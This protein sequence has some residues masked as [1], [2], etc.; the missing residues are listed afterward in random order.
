MSWRSVS[1]RGEEFHRHA[2]AVAKLPVKISL[3]IC[4]AND[5]CAPRQLSPRGTASQLHEEQTHFIP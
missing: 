2:A 5:L 4:F 1:L 3:A